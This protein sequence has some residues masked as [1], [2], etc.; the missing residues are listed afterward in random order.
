MNF[1]LMEFYR[2]F[3]KYYLKDWQE[4]AKHFDRALE[5]EPSLLQAQIGKA[6]SLGIRHRPSEGLAVLLDIETKI[7][8]RAV[9]DPEAVYKLAQ[10]YAVLGDRLSAL[11]VFK[12]A[13]DGGFFPYPYLLTDPLLDNLRSEPEFG[14]L[15]NAALQRQQAFITTFFS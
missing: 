2:G 12:R 9:G 11:R 10:A 5:L 14:Q 7:D 4:A 1:A 13:L 3:A 8:R 15:V 6:L